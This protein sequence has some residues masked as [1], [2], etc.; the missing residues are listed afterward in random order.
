MDDKIASLKSA[1]IVINDL[2]ES[3]VLSAGTRQLLQDLRKE[4]END[5]RFL[6]VQQRDVS[7]S[8]AV[9]QN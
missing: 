9:R 4:T 3:P 1:L 6:L 8:K 5:L 2:L 7:V